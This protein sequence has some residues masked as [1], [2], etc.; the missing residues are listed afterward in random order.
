[1][2]VV[3]TENRTPK[4]L[5]VLIVMFLLGSLGLGFVLL[6]RTNTREVMKYMESEMNTNMETRGYIDSPSVVIMVNYE[7]FLE[8]VNDLNVSIIYKQE[9]YSATSYG[10]YFVFTGDMQIV[11]R[12]KITW[13]E[14]VR[15]AKKYDIQ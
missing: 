7:E 15:I 14:L 10:D 12:L 4:R 11:Y 9:T 5:Y 2:V 3:E 13:T 8:M 1:M 6:P